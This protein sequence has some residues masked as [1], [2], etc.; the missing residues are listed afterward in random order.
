MHADPVPVPYG[1]PIR[2]RRKKYSYSV[3][4]CPAVPAA[5]VCEDDRIIR[6]LIENLLRRGGFVV[7]SAADGRDALLLLEEHDFQ[8]IILD[9]MMPR[10]TGEAVIRHIAAQRPHLLPRVVVTTAAIRESARLGGHAVGAVITK[11][12]DLHEFVETIRSVALANE[13]KE[14]E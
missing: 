13:R 9:L 14:H 10:V 2:K 1:G 11:P 5:L 7:E 8:V 6:S 12:F 4:V 3:L